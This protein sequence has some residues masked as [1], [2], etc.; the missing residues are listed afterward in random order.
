V[1]PGHAEAALSRERAPK[2]HARHPDH[3][4]WR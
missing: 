3:D 2:G 4:F 1:R